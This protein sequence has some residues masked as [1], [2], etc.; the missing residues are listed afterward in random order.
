MLLSA[1]SDGYVLDADQSLQLARQM[2]RSNKPVEACRILV[3][4]LRADSTAAMLYGEL[5]VTLFGLK[6]FERAVQALREAIRLRPDV[7]RYQLNLSGVYHHLG[8]Y[9]ECIDL[10]SRLVERDDRDGM[11]HMNLGL[12]SSC[13]GNWEI[14][15]KHFEKATECMPDHCGAWLNLGLGYENRCLDDK[16]NVCFEK[17]VRLVWKIY[18]R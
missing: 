15:I 9:Q 4:G 17:A 16:A 14:S 10:A 7:A 3:S 2:R 11:A 6:L 8:R 12:A 1:E 5:G 18:F 13:I